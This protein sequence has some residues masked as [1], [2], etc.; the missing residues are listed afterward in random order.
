MANVTEY[1]E[2]GRTFLG[3]CATELKKVVWPTRNETFTFTTVVLVVVAFVSLYLGIVD[4][5][6]SL[7]LG[8]VF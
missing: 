8:L 3:E 7:L 1:V 5:I 6:L 2:Q 4:Y